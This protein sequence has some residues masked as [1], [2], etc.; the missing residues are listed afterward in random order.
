MISLADLKLNQATDMLERADDDV[1]HVIWGNHLTYL[2]VL[3]KYQ[4]AIE[5]AQKLI[6]K[7]EADVLLSNRGDA[8]SQRGKNRTTVD[9]SIQKEDS[10]PG[11]CILEPLERD[12][13]GFG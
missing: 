10:S 8:N 13:P 9:R 11:S 4:Q 2:I 1:R 5:L 12:A 6:T 7:L 3:K